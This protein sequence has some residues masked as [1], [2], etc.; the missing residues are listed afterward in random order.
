MLVLH[1]E[2]VKSRLPDPVPGMDDGGVFPYQPFRFLQVGVSRVADPVKPG[3][4]LALR[5]AAFR[6]VFVL[7]AHSFLLNTG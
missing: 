3:I 2:E 5:M 7:L 6:L 4:G 1:D